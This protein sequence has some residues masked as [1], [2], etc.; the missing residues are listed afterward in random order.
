MRRASGTSRC[1]R[2]RQ[3]KSGGDDELLAQTR[4]VGRGVR[5]PGDCRRRHWRSPGCILAPARRSE[6]RHASPRRG[7]PVRA[8]CT[9]NGAH[10]CASKPSPV[11]Q[12]APPRASASAGARG[13]SSDAG[14]LSRAPGLAA[15]ASPGTH[16]CQT[17][18][19]PVARV[20][21]AGAEPL[22]R[23]C[24]ADASAEPFPHGLSCGASA[25]SVT[26]SRSAGAEPV[27]EGHSQLTVTAA[28]THGQS[29]A[30]GRASRP[31]ICSRR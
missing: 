19:E 13:V 12:P 16:G 17:G 9:R 21:S 31:R 8:A 11:A 6:T 3:Y 2:P 30:A 1:W 26:C 25:E 18:A 29:G 28:A 14:A 22:P 5:H 27:A 10:A 15:A 24:R 7:R 23:K 4:A 20:R